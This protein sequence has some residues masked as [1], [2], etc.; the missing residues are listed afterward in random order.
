M[1]KI[2]QKEIDHIRTNPLTDVIDDKK[3]FLKELSFQ[4]KNLNKNDELKVLIKN[5][6]IIF[7]KD[8]NGIITFE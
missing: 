7:K 6:I 2:T 3:E 4:I 1:A 8:V 5:E